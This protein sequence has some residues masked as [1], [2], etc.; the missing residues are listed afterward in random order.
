MTKQNLFILTLI[1]F[2]SFQINTN[3]QD[4]D[5][6]ISAPTINQMRLPILPAKDKKTYNSLE[7]EVAIVISEVAKLPLALRSSISGKSSRTRF[8][9]SPEGVSLLLCVQA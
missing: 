1:L 3:A 8:R 6:T 2:L 9:S 4:I 7:D 5:S